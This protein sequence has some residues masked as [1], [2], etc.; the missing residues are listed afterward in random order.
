MCENGCHTQHMY[1]APV[2][3]QCIPY[4]C[5]MQDGLYLICAFMG[6]LSIFSFSLLHTRKI[7]YGA[8]CNIKV[9]AWRAMRICDILVPTRKNAFVQVGNK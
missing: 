6:F 7:D 3:Q 5:I 2:F 9:A 1:C 8:L 4:M